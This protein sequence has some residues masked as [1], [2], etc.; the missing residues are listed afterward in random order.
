M[1]SQAVLFD[2]AI[3]VHERQPSSSTRRGALVAGHREAGVVRIGDET[4]A[5]IGQRMSLRDLHAGVARIVVDHADFDH[6]FGGAQARFIGCGC[7]TGRERFK[8]FRELTRHAV[9]ALAKIA[10]GKATKVFLP[11][12]T[13]GVLGSIA[14]IGELLNEKTPAGVK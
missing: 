9:E 4:Q 1:T 11:L 12:E 2:E 8:L 3:R 14:G 5:R 13:T 7:E 6:A 10:D